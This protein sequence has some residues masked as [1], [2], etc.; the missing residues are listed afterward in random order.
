MKSVTAVFDQQNRGLFAV[1]ML[2]AF[3]ATIIIAGSFTAT[4]ADNGVEETC[5]ADSYD[6]DTVSSED[7]AAWYFNLN[8]KSSDPAKGS[9]AEEKQSVPM[10]PRKSAEPALVSALAI[11]NGDFG[12][13]ITVKITMIIILPFPTW[14]NFNFATPA[15]GYEMD[16]WTMNGTQGDVF[17]VLRDGSTFEAHFK[18]KGVEHS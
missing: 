11:T 9:V 2:T 14:I 16:Y 5:V 13:V 15:D 12:M 17:K 8:F 3:A 1:L 7:N 6:A 18:E 10:A 4:D